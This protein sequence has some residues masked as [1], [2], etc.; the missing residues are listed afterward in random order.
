MNETTPKR[1]LSLD[2]GGLRGVASI[3]FLERLEAKL[4]A[5]YGRPIAL[6]EHFDLIG[7]T[8]TGS[9]I[10]TG[11][12]LGQ[13]LSEIKDHY[14]RLAPNVFRRAWNRIPLVHAIFSA[15]AL[16]REFLGIVG[17]RTLAT[18]DLKTGLAIITKRVDTGAV[19]FLTNNAGAPY[20]D[21]PEDGSFIGNRHYS[22]ANVIRAST[23]APHFFDPHLIEIVK[24]KTTGLFVDGG[25]SPHNNPALAL[26]QIATVPA[27]GYNWPAG[28]NRLEITSVGTGSFRYLVDRKTFASRF[29]AS[30]AIDAL[31]SMMAD[32][33]A[34]VLTVMQTLGRCQT[35]W[36]INTEIG[37]LCGVCIAPEPLFT[38]R[39]YDLVLEQPWLKDMLGVDIS[40]R[41]LARLRDITS[42]STMETI[43]SMAAAAA[44]KQMPSH[45]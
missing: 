41:D 10:A 20:W 34:M 6:H 13:P 43:Y 16:Q 24:G 35:P 27:Y 3:A 12:A 8:S 31:R 25:V 9:I 37:N 44:D 18:P 5:D 40:A 36:S 33:D 11:L 30:R 7:G 2:G 38:F 22:L 14:F 28:G 4:Q 32:N 45:I 42:L 23:A 17:D 26:L 21:D 39:R 29:A 19:W 15:E 1:I